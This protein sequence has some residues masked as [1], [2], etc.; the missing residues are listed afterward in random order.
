MHRLAAAILADFR[1]LRARAWVWVLWGA[2]PCVGIAIFVSHSTAH[3]A[4]SRLSPTGYIDPRYMIDGIGAIPLWLAC[5][6]VLCL[7]LDLNRIDRRD[8]VSQAVFA[9]PLAN[10]QLV[11]GRLCALA[12]TAWVSLLVLAIALQTIGIASQLLD[13]PMG[14]AVG[15][16]SLTGFLVV[17][18]MPAIIIFTGLV[19]LLTANGSRV[20]A[21]APLIVLAI[22]I[23]VLFHAPAYLR[24]AVS[25]VGTLGGTAS[26]FLPEFTNGDKLLRG[27]SAT[28]I[29]AGL[30]VIAAALH[31]RLD[32]IRPIRILAAGL[33]FALP[34]AIGIA[35]LTTGGLD[36]IAVRDAWAEAHASMSDRP[37]ADVERLSAHVGID[38]GER[39]TVEA[40]LHLV[41]PPT[42]ANPDLVLSFNPG[43]RIEEVHLNSRKVNFRHEL[44]ILTIM[45]DQEG[46][47]EDATLFVKSS[48][49]P[50]PQFAYLDSVVDVQRA[51]LADSH[52]H[53]LGTE[54]SIFSTSY[55]ALMPGVRWLPFPGVNYQAEVPRQP[56]RDFFEL[57][58]EV[59]VPSDWIAIGP[60]P[61]AKVDRLGP[62]HTYRFQPAAPLTDFGIFASPLHK[63]QS[64]SING[65]TFDIF[66]HAK[67]QRNVDHVGRGVVEHYFGL[68]PMMLDSLAADV[69]FPYGGLSIVEVPSTLRVYGGGWRLDSVLGLPGIFLLREYGLPT[70]KLASPWGDDVIFRT[71]Y[72]G[73]YLDRDYSGG[74]LVSA[75]SRHLTYFQTSPIGDESI[76]LDL[77][78]ELLSANMLEQSCS[79]TFGRERRIFSAHRFHG[80]SLRRPVFSAA[81]ARVMGNTSEIRAELER[82]EQINASAWDVLERIPVSQ[83]VAAVAPDRAIAA[84]ELKMGKMAE[85]LTDTWGRQKLTT[86]V[87]ALTQEHGGGSFSSSDLEAVAAGLD[88]PLQPLVGNWI[89]GTDLPGFVVSP[90]AVTRL[91]DDGQQTPVYQSTLH[92]RNDESVPGYVKL[93]WHSSPDEYGEAGP[94]RVEG[95]ASVEVGFTSASPPKWVSLN[96]YLSL[97][98]KKVRIETIQEGP[99]DSTETR[100]FTGVRTSD[101]FPP[102]E[103]IVVDDLDPGFRIVR[104][105]PNG[106][107]V[108]LPRY[109]NPYRTDFDGGMPIY[110]MCCGMGKGR[111]QRAYEPWAWGKYRRTYVRAS[112]G[113]GEEIAVFT[114]ELPH[115]GSWHLDYHLPGRYDWRNPEQAL[116][117]DD[118]G[119]ST[120]VLSSNGQDVAIAFDGS[121]AHQ[122]WNDLGAY[123]LTAGSVQVRVS[124]ATGQQSVVAD[125]VRFRPVL[126]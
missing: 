2:V 101:W 88:L 93:T 23:Y 76:A 8:R 54:A 65:L 73:D 35:Y 40:T 106:H 18:S 113:D 112:H 108:E 3:Y 38:P 48:G 104:A 62:T 72:L 126:R 37:K 74:N 57:D 21:V 5:A 86:F 80:P 27:A 46:T 70:A 64:V 116:P 102:Q 115:A 15:S 85:L 84:L 14:G 16:A 60:G 63:K 36:E 94:F 111:W 33:A 66:L 98:R 118:L 7:A 121:A 29:G 79:C 26:D 90:I 41:L 34:G 19:L 119:I 52:L 110:P 99:I 123:D 39:L 49:V 31:P 58:L 97:N 9:R 71:L 30:C 96:P 67:H 25:I 45:L 51:S 55:V 28:L 78:L 100:P 17:D 10:I 61:P 124:S 81:M 77:L 20:L 103:G 4:H 114:V 125:A 53:L 75:T 24:P 44:G 6:G 42:A 47:Y 59:T 56:V 122:G 117:H 92:V 87:R 83:I 91:P 95:N 107:R 89:N 105:P 12:G 22:Q 50:D 82:R 120:V 68:E 69:F 43:N 32:S 109:N 11:L 13:W 1:S